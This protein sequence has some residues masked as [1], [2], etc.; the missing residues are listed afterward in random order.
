[1]AFFDVEAGEGAEMKQS[2]SWSIA[3][4]D[5]EIEVGL[6]R[7]RVIMRVSEACLARF[8]RSMQHDSLV[9]SLGS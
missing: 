2:S 6:E 9:G 8:A 5:F 1:M 3:M 7:E 4:V